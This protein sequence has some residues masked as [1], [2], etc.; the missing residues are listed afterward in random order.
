MSTVTATIDVS[1]P[2]GRRI[3]RDLDKHSKVV[4]LNFPLPDGI[5]EK[6]YTHQEVWS[7]MEKRMNDFYGSDLKI[8]T[9]FL[10]L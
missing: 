5:S 6:T 7:K 2:T 3:V 1:K 4:S 9:N 10:L 8:Q